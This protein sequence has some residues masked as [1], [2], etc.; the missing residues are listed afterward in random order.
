M[1]LRTAPVWFSKG[2]QLVHPD[3]F[4]AYYD[5][6]Y[7]WQIRKWRFHSNQPDDLYPNYHFF[8]P[9][10]LAMN[11]ILV[12]KVKHEGTGGVDLG[13]Q[14]L[15]GDVLDAVQRGYWNAKHVVEF[16]KETDQSN[17][18]IATD[19]QKDLDDMSRY[20]AT[21]IWHRYQEPEVFIHRGDSNVTD[22]SG[23]NSASA[24]PDKGANA[25]VLA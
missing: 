14:D 24:Q 2:L 18:K 4:A 21:R 8:E 15:V 7:R 16:M 17:D 1:S 3:Y 25:E 12:L 20:M 11:S 19:G 9:K 13:Y 5:R 23:C 10:S 6:F 22:S